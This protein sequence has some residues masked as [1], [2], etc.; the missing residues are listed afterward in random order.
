MSVSMTIIT[1][2]P[3]SVSITIYLFIYSLF[4]DAVSSLVIKDFGG[5]EI[6]VFGLRGCQ[7]CTLV[8]S[9]QHFRGRCCPHYHG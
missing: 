4:N 3:T 2:G 5:T 7:P 1:L 6:K 9:S 8:T